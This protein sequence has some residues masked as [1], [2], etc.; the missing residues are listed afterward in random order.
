MKK[1]FVSIIIPNYNCEKYLISC[2]N[3]IECQTYKKIEV[4]IV[5]D[6]SNDSSL[7]IINSYKKESKYEV[8][9]IFQFNQNAAVARNRGIDVSKGEYLFFLDSDDELYAPN[10][11]EKMVSFIDKNDLLL[12]N[13]EV[14]DDGNM[15]IKN[16]SVEDNLLKY[17]GVYKYV[18]NSPVPSNKLYKNLIVRN[19]NIFFSNVRIGQ[20]LNFYLKY[21]AVCKNVVSCDFMSYKYRILDNSITRKNNLNFLDIY[22]CFDGVKNFYFNNNIGELYD[23]YIANVSLEH[24]HQQFSKIV[25]FKQRK[26]KK[27]I[28]CFFKFC[29]ADC[30]KNSINKDSYYK[31]NVRLFN[32][33]IVLYKLGVL[34]VAK[35]ISKNKRKG[36]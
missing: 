19:N 1:G 5:D 34:S 32:F 28:Y 21:L 33:K 35:I 26:I 16:Y 23:K 3:S 17:P 31:H 24:Y 10:V 6:G 9:T 8:I 30:K 14:V 29:F 25:N 18:R 27:F 12:C 2:L 4:I 15:K 11:I 7:D 20:D 22:N 36:V 13:Y